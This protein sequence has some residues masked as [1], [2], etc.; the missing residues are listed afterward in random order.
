MFMLP[1]DYLLIRAAPLQF[2]F[3]IFLLQSSLHLM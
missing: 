3:A 2:E 1:A